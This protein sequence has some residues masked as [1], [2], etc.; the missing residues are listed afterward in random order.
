MDSNNDFDIIDIQDKIKKIKVF[1]NSLDKNK[2]QDIIDSM[3]NI[4]LEY[5]DDIKKN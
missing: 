5:E 4:I 1:I 3:N 2:Y